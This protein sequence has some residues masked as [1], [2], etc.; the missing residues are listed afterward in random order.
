MLSKINGSIE[1]VS[2]T[3]KL[4]K[5]VITYCFRGKSLQIYDINNYE[6]TRE[7]ELKSTDNFGFGIS[8]TL[9]LVALG[10]D[11]PP[12]QISLYDYKTSK[13]VGELKGHTN[14]FQWHPF[15]FLDKEKKLLSASHDGTIKLWNLVTF[16]LLSS[17]NHGFKC[18]YCCTRI[19]ETSKI[20]IGGYNPND[21]KIFDIKTRQYV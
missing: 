2:N 16:K 4:K 8:T 14:G 5:E 13:L 7:I 10:N 17:T 1:Q 11:S 15:V 19:P 6:L 12:Y 20:A 3:K 18:V 21:I 9:R